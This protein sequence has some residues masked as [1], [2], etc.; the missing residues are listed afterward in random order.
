MVTSVMEGPLSPMMHLQNR[1]GLHRDALLVIAFLQDK[2]SRPLWLQGARAFISL[3][4]LKEQVT[5]YGPQALLPF[6]LWGSQSTFC[7]SVTPRPVVM[8]NWRLHRKLG[9]LP[10]TGPLSRRKLLTRNTGATKAA[11][12]YWARRVIVWI[13]RAFKHSWQARPGQREDAARV[14][15]LKVYH[16]QREWHWRVDPSVSW[17]IWWW[18]PHKTMCF[19]EHLFGTSWEQCQMVGSRMEWGACV[20][21]ASIFPDSLPSEAGTSQSVLRCAGS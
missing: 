16:V 8:I 17:H 9:G 18:A 12:G 11:P 20:S 3:L 10:A 1:K 19:P 6:E 4:S 14:I 2:P 13:L 15:A 21:Y 7:F 5:A